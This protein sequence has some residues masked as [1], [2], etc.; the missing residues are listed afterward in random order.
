MSEP[1]HILSIWFVRSNN[2]YARLVAVLLLRAEHIPSTF[3]PFSSPRLRYVY[4]YL[5][6]S[7]AVARNSS[8]ITYR[9]VFSIVR[10]MEFE[11]FVEAAVGAVGRGRLLGTI[12]VCR[13]FKGHRHT[14][15]PAI[16]QWLSA[17]IG[18]AWNCVS[19][20]LWSARLEVREKPR[21][22]PQI[23]QF[24]HGHCSLCL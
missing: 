11:F 16:F 20:A 2:L 13:C 12:F 10:R 15:H 1:I 8:M 22:L 4:I 14:Q 9:T 5:C 7:A 18:R 6:L 24:S 3:Q 17:V 23:T 19:I 21:N